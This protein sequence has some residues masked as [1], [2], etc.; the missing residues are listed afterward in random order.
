MRNK[1]MI[2]CILIFI[3]MVSVGVGALYVKDMMV[4]TYKKVTIDDYGI[5]M[6]YP[7]AYEDVVKN[8]STEYELLSGRITTVAEEYEKSG[9]SLIE[10]TSELLNSKSKVSGITLLVEGLKIAKTSKSIE[11]IC[12]DYKVMFKIYNPNATVEKFDY[13]EVL[14]D[15]KPAGRVEIFIRN[16]DKDRK[17]SPGIIAYLISLDDREITITFMGTENLLKNAKDEINK[18]VSSIKLK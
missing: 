12:K 10:F 14:I 3:L 18:I 15:G 13:E 4:Y 7:R 1:K 16:E 8:V 17:S 11:Q 6:K 9:D 2:L 5:E